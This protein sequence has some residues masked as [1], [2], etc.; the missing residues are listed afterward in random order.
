MAKLGVLSLALIGVLW[1]NEGRA[2]RLAAW[3]QPPTSKP[4][5]P[6]VSLLYQITIG[7]KMV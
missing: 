2:P 7:V 4:F 6:H 5:H 1:I 3:T